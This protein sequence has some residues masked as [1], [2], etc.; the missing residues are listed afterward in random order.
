MQLAYSN[1]AAHWAMP[2]PPENGVKPETGFLV[3]VVPVARI[4]EWCA[5][6]AWIYPHVIDEDRYA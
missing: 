2:W 4:M 1:S 5:P 3:H 6:P